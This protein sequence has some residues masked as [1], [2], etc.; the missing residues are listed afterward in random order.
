MGKLTMSHIVDS[1]WQRINIFMALL[2]AMYKFISL[3]SEV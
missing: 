2:G 3:R 1:L